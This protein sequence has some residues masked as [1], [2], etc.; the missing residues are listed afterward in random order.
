MVEL[1]WGLGPY[2]QSGTSLLPSAGMERPVR[3]TRPGFAAPP[4]EPDEP[5]PG[6]DLGGRPAGRKQKERGMLRLDD[7]TFAVLN[8]YAADV[9][10]PRAV[11]IRE[12]IW[13][14]C[15]TT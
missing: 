2:G 7:D 15:S 9:G 12:A 13:H 8:E 6:R 5:A 1:H 4:P 3:R 10:K 11:V 14:L